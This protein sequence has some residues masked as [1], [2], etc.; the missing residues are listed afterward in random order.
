M[1]DS[2]LM[3]DRA[4]SCRK[5]GHSSL[6]APFV[7]PNSNKTKPENLLVF[8]LTVRFFLQRELTSIH[9]SRVKNHLVDNLVNPSYVKI[10]D[11]K[12]LYSSQLKFTVL[13]L[14]DVP[15]EMEFSTCSQE[16]VQEF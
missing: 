3:A 7:I 9:S 1:S 2:E 16:Q 15:I 11:M 13:Y 4:T 8:N 14:E 10:R 6:K 5:V 12:T